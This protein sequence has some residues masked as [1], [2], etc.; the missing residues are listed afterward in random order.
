MGGV[1]YMGEGG[2]RERKAGDGR[3]E[4]SQRGGKKEHSF[5]VVQVLE[6]SFGEQG[7]LGRCVSLRFRRPTR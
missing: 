7:E 2:R 6:V 4:I 1:G 3:S 5:G